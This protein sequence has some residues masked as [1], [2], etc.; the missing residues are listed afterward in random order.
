MRYK[1]EFDLNSRWDRICLKQTDEI[2]WLIHTVYF[3]WLYFCTVDA[4]RAGNG[5]LVVIISV[6]GLNVPN[7]VHQD[8]PDQYRFSFKPNLAKRHEVTVSF[9]QNV[10]ILLSQRY[11]SNINVDIYRCHVSP[12]D[13]PADFLEKS[14]V[15]SCKW[16][17]L[18]GLFPHKINF[19]T[20][21]YAMERC[22]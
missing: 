13:I 16:L 18:N 6:D 22:L 11:L 20:K 19:V 21:Q 2:C 12:S 5:K 4:S 7:T 3:C 14:C 1:D 15:W 17:M 8:G 10:S 9:L